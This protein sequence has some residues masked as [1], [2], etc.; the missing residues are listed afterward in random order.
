MRLQ[1][2]EEQ[3]KKCIRDKSGAEKTR[4]RAEKVRIAK[5]YLIK[6]FEHSLK[7]TIEK[8]LT[9]REKQIA[10]LEQV[11]EVWES[12]TVDEIILRYTDEQT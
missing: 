3:L 7:P 5:L 6:A 4:N 12:I 11:R 1:K 2:V 10:N 9:A 8:D